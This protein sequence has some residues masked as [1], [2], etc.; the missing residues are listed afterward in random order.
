MTLKKTSKS[1]I[2]RIMKKVV[3]TIIKYAI[4]GLV[5]L[6]K[7]LPA[8]RYVYEQILNR[9]MG[10]IQ[11]VSHSGINLIFAVPNSL[12][13]YRA[14]S[15]STKEPETL[16]WID[17][18]PEG[19]IVWDI[20]A[21]VGLYSCYAAKRR[22]CRVFAFEPSVFN[23]ELLARNLFLNGLTDQVTIVP[24]PLS[25]ALAINKLNM[26]TT[27]WGGA[28]STF[29]QNYG[30]DGKALS[31]VFEFPTIG[32]TMGDAVEFLKLPQPDYI[33]MDVDGIEHLILK[34]GASVLPRIKGIL[35]EI[36]DNFASQTEDSTKY[37]KNAGLSLINKKHAQA[38]E[39]S[40]EFKSV[41]NQIWFRSEPI[42]N[43]KER[44]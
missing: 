5:V 4:N 11:V 25:D 9:S 24:L 42:N 26:T 12:N 10:Q 30:H 44:L 31:K 21:N 20:G 41:F 14:D 2:E 40:E 7:H 6:I 8:G 39:E 27:E 34:G 17:S 43:I 18:M 29:G 32:L 16:E 1:Y 22:K 23:L 15:F 33:K 3:K 19:S 38:L 37:L 13:K 35:I 36:N 28:L